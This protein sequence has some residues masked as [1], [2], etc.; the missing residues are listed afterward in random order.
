MSLLGAPI[1]LNGWSAS[2]LSPC[3]PELFLAANEVDGYR[4]STSLEGAVRKCLLPISLDDRAEIWMSRDLKVFPNSEYANAIF[5][6]AISSFWGKGGRGIPNSKPLST[7]F[8]ILTHRLNKTDIDNYFVRT[9]GRWFFLDTMLKLPSPL[10]PL[11]DFPGNQSGPNP[12]MASETP[13]RL[14]CL[15]LIGLV[16]TTIRFRKMPRGTA[17][18][19]DKLSALDYLAG[20]IL[21]MGF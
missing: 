9:P 11:D 7:I 10:S 18:R 4:F 8:A 19:N 13:R 6:I 16:L 2:E 15:S 5:P 20:Q 14:F 1:P 3:N 12:R 21:K 17:G